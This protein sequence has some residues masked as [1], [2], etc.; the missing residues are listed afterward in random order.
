MKLYRVIDKDGNFIRDDFY[1]DEGTEIGL[2]VE[3]SQGF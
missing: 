1:F 3:A 2:E